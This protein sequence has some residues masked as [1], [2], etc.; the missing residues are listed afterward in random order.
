MT[1]PI[2]V[3][4]VFTI[5]NR[6][7]AETMVMNYYRH[8][9]RDR[10]QFDFLVCRPERGAYEDEIEAMGGRIYRVPP[11]F[12]VVAHRAGVRAFLDEHAE[13]RIIH[14]HVGELGYFIYKEARVRGVPCIIA[15]A[16]SNFCDKDWKLPLRYVLKYLIRKHVTHMMTCGVSAAQWYFGKENAKHA[17]MLNNAIESSKYRF[18][19]HEYGQVRQEQG[20]E[21]RWVIGNVARFS[22]PKNHIFLIKIFSE[23]FKEKPNALLVLIGKTEGREY[24]RIFG[25]VQ[26]LGLLDCVLFLGSR[27]DVP[28]LLK[29]MDV[30]CFPSLYEGFGIAMLEAEASGLHVV[31]SSQVPD[32]AVVVSDLV[33]S[34]PLN[35]P[36]SQWKNELTKFRP[37][38]DTYVD[39]S[40]AGFDISKNAQ[41]LQQFYLDQV[42][43][44]E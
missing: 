17:I 23:I 34:L 1:S 29:G 21:G 19:Q 37:R 2:R 3:L 43:T 33:T 12:D 5:L 25:Q 28:N 44:M 11:V 10:V 6:G 7:G 16:H 41:W 30:F 31:K 18:S 32:D 20:W 42:Q 35:A 8:M 15:H 4:Q 39:I 40:E 14:G 38:R 36:M 13:Y 27:N 26:R 9:D 24:E 22:P